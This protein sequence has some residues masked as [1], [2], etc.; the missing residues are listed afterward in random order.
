MLGARSAAIPDD[1]RGSSR[2]K[3]IFR[4]EYR[5]LR[6]GKYL[7]RPYLA[8]CYTQTWR[9]KD[10]RERKGNDRENCSNALEERQGG[11]SNLGYLVSRKIRSADTSKSPRATHR[12]DE[13]NDDK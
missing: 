6:K 5:A 8:A 3:M 9:A 7:P 4:R 2:G 1:N 10:I 13:E 11:L 12:N